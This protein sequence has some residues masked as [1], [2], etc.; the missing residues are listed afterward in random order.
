MGSLSAQI[1]MENGNHTYINEQVSR[2]LHSRQI[3]DLKVFMEGR[4]AV[5]FKS[6]PVTKMILGSGT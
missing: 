6:F 5:S 4:F 2:T 1:Y 3:N